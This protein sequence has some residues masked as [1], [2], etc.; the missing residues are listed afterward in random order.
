MTEKRKRKPDELL[1]DS[2]GFDEDDLAAN[3]A[4]RLGASQQSRLQRM[5]K[6]ATTDSTMGIIAGVG[7][8]LL[9]LVFLVPI[10]QTSIACVLLGI[11]PVAIAA[12]IFGQARRSQ[13]VARTDML[14]LQ[15][16]IVERIEGLVSL[17]VRERGGTT[18]YA[19]R[20]EGWEWIVN[21]EV[22]LAFKNGDPY[23]LYYTLHSNMLLAAEW[24]REPPPG[25]DQPADSDE[26]EWADTQAKPKRGSMG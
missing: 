26:A 24:L 18:A 19:V 21:R 12:F 1:M 14:D 17:D 13:R 22:F 11:V 15:N 10:L 23:A 9:G 25:M 4:G 2:L 6:T 16:Q 8:L 3:R 20:L 5:Q 7:V